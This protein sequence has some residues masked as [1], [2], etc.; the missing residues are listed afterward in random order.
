MHKGPGDLGLSNMFSLN[1]L[2]AKLR[3]EDSPVHLAAFY[4]RAGV[5]E[6]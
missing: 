4:G 6:S 1:L 3:S 5:S 2:A